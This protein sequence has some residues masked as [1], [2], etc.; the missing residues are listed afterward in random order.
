MT[1]KISFICTLIIVFLTPA[2]FYTGTRDNFLIKETIFGIFGLAVALL[3]ILRILVKKQRLTGGW[4]GIPVL[5]YVAAITASNVNAT[6]HQMVFEFLFVWIILASLYFTARDFSEAESGK[7][8]SAIFISS[9][10]AG[11]YG[12]LQY[13]NLD[14]VR[15]LYDF[16]GRPS[17]TFGNPNFFSGYLLLVFPMIF[18]KMIS[19]RKPAA[20]IFWMFFCFLAVFNIGLARTRGAWVAFF[21]AV[22]CLTAGQMIYL[23]MTFV[24][25]K[26]MFRGTFWFFLLFS[27]IFIISI[28]R[29]ATI[30]TFFGGENLS[31]SERVFKWKTGWEMIKEHPLLGVGAGNLKVDFARYQSK[32]EKKIRL[33]SSSESNLHNEFLQ[34]WA[35]TGIFG[36]AAFLSVFIFFFIRCAGLLYK[37]MKSDESEFNMMMGIFTGVFSVFVY[38]LTNFP[39]SI[40]PVSSTVFVLF[41]ISESFGGKKYIS[42][43]PQKHPSP[44]LLLIFS[45]FWIFLILE[46]IIPRFTSDLARRRGDI[47]FSVN[48]LS[49]AAG[50]YEKAV[51]SDYY[52]S[53]RTA[54]DLGEAYRKLNQIDRAIDA[55]KISAS[56][57]NYGEVYNDIGNCYYLK[58][59][60]GNALFYWKKAVEIGLPD[61][62]VQN[63]VLKS[64]SVLEKNKHVE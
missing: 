24:T 28:D 58:N 35:E 16:G 46:V 60:S 32:V 30:K 61:D 1:K 12:I 6:Y 63:Q 26:R 59:D 10:A 42:P 64:I 31:V 51:R 3:L 27:A 4:L 9:F 55:Y 37:K 48:A 8:F 18:I 45:V 11:I 21:A 23:K 54:F 33:K 52:H 25:V 29:F 62:D 43:V 50:E 14:P 5:M 53:E 44:L 7:I 34:R 38:G 22:V 20:H 17:S 19:T 56:L 40:I 41:G 36:L 49:L 47:Y 39:L 13:L 15:W 2:V 57:R